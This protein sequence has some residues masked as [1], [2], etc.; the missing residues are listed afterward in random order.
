MDIGPHCAVIVLE[1]DK[2]LPV[3]QGPRPTVPSNLPMKEHL[4]VMMR[5]A[6]VQ[7]LSQKQRRKNALVSVVCPEGRPA[8]ETLC[9]RMAAENG[10]DHSNILFSIGW[11]KTMRDAA[12]EVCFVCDCI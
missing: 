9:I 10:E 8:Q 3:V 6:M 11:I 1:A 5:Q 7:G 12:S 4:L 2:P